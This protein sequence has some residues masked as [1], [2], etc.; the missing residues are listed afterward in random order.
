MSQRR[1]QGDVHVGTMAGD[2]R[3]VPGSGTENGDKALADFMRDVL[4]RVRRSIRE[5]ASARR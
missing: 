2:V 4:E 1:I 3:R 5:R